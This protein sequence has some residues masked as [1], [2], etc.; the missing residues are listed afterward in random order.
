MAEHTN[1]PALLITDLELSGGPGFDR[2]RSETRRCSLAE[3]LAAN[4]EAEETCEAVRAL[5]PGDAVELG[6]GAC[7][8]VEVRRSWEGERVTH[9][10]GNRPA[11]VLGSWLQ[12]NGVE[13]VDLRWEGRYAFLCIPRAE[14]DLY[15]RWAPRVEAPPSPNALRDLARELPDPRGELAA[16]FP[17]RDPDGHMGATEGA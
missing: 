6:G 14:F 12:G 13:M 4:H 16:C 5:T 17:V 10:W 8:L 7:P 1:G 9:T 3:F 2:I 15:W 11:R